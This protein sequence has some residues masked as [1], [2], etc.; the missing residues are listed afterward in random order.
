MVSGARKRLERLSVGCAADPLGKAHGDGLHGYLGQP[1]ASAQLGRAL[2]ELA[3]L[4]GLL[5]LEC[6]GLLDNDLFALLVHQVTRR[7]IKSP[8]F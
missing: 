6:D 1:L 8:R 7:R 5:E 3:P 4:A 2:G